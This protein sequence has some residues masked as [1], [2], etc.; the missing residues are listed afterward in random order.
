M[1][2]IVGSYVAVCLEVFNMYESV[3]VTQGWVPRILGES[4]HQ[5]TA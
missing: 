1:S 5:V 2:Y 3:I 4:V